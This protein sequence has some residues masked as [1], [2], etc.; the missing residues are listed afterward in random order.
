[1]LFIQKQNFIEKF[2]AKFIINFRSTTVVF[3]Q[4]F[5]DTKKLFFN[6]TK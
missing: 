4:L 5:C 2:D 1:M 6:Q 3:V